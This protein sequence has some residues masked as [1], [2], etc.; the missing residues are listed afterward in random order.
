MYKKVS[1]IIALLIVII[2]Q[3][4]KFFAVKHLAQTIEITSFL[5]FSLVYNKGI[6]F[7]LF[8]KL[9][10]SNYFLAIIASSISFVLYKWL[11]TSKSKLESL[12]LG[13][14]LGGAIGNISD[15]FF[16]PGVVDFIE[17]HWKEY[18]WPNFNIAD[19]AI[20]IGI[21]FL[22]IFSINSKNKN[23]LIEI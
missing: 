10:Y 13:I 2:D 15:R 12:C 7:G 3:I 14:I 19:S 21:C 23:N 1:L 8:N 11:L 16:Y 20:C 6:S 22:L 9:P 18:F 17:L 4:T 5:N